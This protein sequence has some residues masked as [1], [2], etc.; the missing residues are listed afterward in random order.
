[1]WSVA[2]YKSLR[3]ITTFPGF[4]H[5]SDCSCNQISRRLWCGEFKNLSSKWR[6]NLNSCCGIWIK[7]RVLPRLWCRYQLQL[8]FNSWPRNVYMLEMWTKKGGKCIIS[9]RKTPTPSQHKEISF[10]FW[11]Q[12]KHFGVSYPDLFIDDAVNLPVLSVL[13]N[14]RLYTKPSIYWTLSSIHTMTLKVLVPVSVVLQKAPQENHST[15]Y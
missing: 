11:R 6:H 15:D 2:L 9:H 8:W 13:Q 12:L 14:R 1:M 10:G 5:G 4:N 3:Q 7:D